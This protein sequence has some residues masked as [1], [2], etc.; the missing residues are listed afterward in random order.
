MTKKGVLILLFS[1]ASF[2]LFA[3]GQDNNWLWAHSWLSFN[4]T[5][6]SS[7]MS[8]L[9]TQFNSN[10]VS[11]ASV[12]S[13]TGALLFYLDNYVITNAAHNPMPNGNL[14][15]GINSLGTLWPCKQDVLIVP[16]PGN[17]NRYYLFV[18]AHNFTYSELRYCIIDMTLQAGFGDVITTSKNILV[19]NNIMAPLTAVKQMGTNNFWILTNFN[20]GFKAFLLT[21]SG[22]NTT[23]VTSI[24]G[25]QVP[26]FGAHLN[27]RV[28]PQGT[29]VARTYFPFQSYGLLV[30][31]STELYDFNASTG[32]FSNYQLLNSGLLYSNGGTLYASIEFS[33]NGNILYRVHN[34]LN[35]FA[36]PTGTQPGTMIQ[37]D[38][39]NNNAKTYIPILLPP[40]TWVTDLKLAPNG[41][42]YIMECYGSSPAI[43]VINQPNIVGVGCNYTYASQPLSSC[44]TTAFTSFPNLVPSLMGSFAP[45]IDSQYATNVAYTTATL[46]ARVCWDGN[47][48]VT[49]RGFYYGTSPLPLSDSAIVS[50]ATGPYIANL[51]G[52]TPNTLYYYRAFA[53]NANG[54][55]ILYDST[56]HTL[57]PNY[58]PLIKYVHNKATCVPDTM[59]FVV[60]DD[61]TSPANTTLSCTSSNTS[62]LPLSSITITGADTNKVL[63]FTPTPYQSG[64]SLITLTATDSNGASSTQS[65]SVTVAAGVPIAI[66]SLNAVTVCQGDSVV[67]QCAIPQGTTIN[68]YVNA[69]PSGNGNPQFAT[70]QSAS[71]YAVCTNAQGCA[72]VSN[73]INATVKPVP[74]V[75]CTVNGPT[76]ICVGDSVQVQAL[77]TAGYSYQ[78]FKNTQLLPNATNAIYYAKQNGDYSYVATLNGC[79][80]TSNIQSIQVVPAPIASIS[81]PNTTMICNGQ[82]ALLQAASGVGYTYQWTMNGFN[83][84]GATNPTYTATIGSYYTVKVSNGYCARTSSPITITVNTAPVAIIHWNGTQ[85]FSPISFY[86]YQWYFNGVLIPGATGQYYTP[87]QAGLY[88]VMVGNENGCKSL[89]PNYN[90]LTL[91]INSLNTPSLSIYPNPTTGMLQVADFKEGTLYVYNAMGQLIIKQTDPL[92]DLSK[93]ANG[94]YQ[95][96]A[97]NQAQELFGIGRVVKE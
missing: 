92:I 94:I 29:K 90:L 80:K 63:S 7:P 77:S 67:M 64:T 28:N 22:V 32:T 2:E 65:F 15:S 48:T 97:Y 88:Y 33:L 17:S 93:Q 86:S 83:I 30:S 76:T 78:W 96:R 8:F 35:I 6:P 79:S 34:Q 73:T 61:D 20:N 38:L 81:T 59:R 54:T 12:S 21:P 4:T 82:G 23:P 70:T 71:V 95:I 39:S 5:P 14:C 18:A 19:A 11:S 91:S 46:H 50:G 56:F 52:L 24:I 85:L 55:T 47:A 58:P 51:T 13:S 57:K 84:A 43:S 31:D 74:Q 36:S 16:D 27:I 37:Y 26:Y 3:Q 66:S 69:T 10:D 68:W 40:G 62:L 41:K 87:T 60:V 75:Q 25:P 49:K 72:T 45:Y 53:T 42:I 89:S 44:M 9:P 1:L